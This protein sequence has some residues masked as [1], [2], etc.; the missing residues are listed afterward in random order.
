MVKYGGRGGAGRVRNQLFILREVNISKL[1]L[2]LSLETSKKFV[3]GGG[4]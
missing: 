2:L 4:G 1:N 3:V